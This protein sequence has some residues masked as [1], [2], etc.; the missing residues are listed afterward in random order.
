MPKRGLGQPGQGHQRDEL[1]GDEPRHGRLDG[2]DLA[3]R[4]AF[5][6]PR[7]FCRDLPKRPHDAPPLQGEGEQAG[8]D[9]AGHAAPEGPL[10][11]VSKPESG[12]DALC[13]RIGT[14]TAQ[15]SVPPSS[16]LAETRRPVSAP[17][18]MKIGSQSN[19]TVRPIHALPKTVSFSLSTNALIE[20][21]S[22]ACEPH[23]S[24]SCEAVGPELV[25]GG[26]QRR[27][28]PGPWP[29]GRPC[30]RASAARGAFPRRR[31]RWESG[32]ARC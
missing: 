28:C 21:G 14:K 10:H 9:H 22:K 1:P 16:M 5:A 7:T 27:R 15:Q 8:S 4:A 26:Q 25:D 6:A 12:D 11:Q 31:C 19:I 30:R 20:Q 3:G 18:A 2:V 17:A 32:A 13:W 24:M 29:S 23:L